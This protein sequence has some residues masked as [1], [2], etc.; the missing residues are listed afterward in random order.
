M[1][2]G[3]LESC[4]HYLNYTLVQ[5]K[6]DSFTCSV[7]ALT[8]WFHLNLIGIFKKFRLFPIKSY[9]CFYC[10]TY[11]KQMG[12]ITGRK[13]SHK[14]APPEKEIIY[15]LVFTLC[16]LVSFI[17]WNFIHLFIMGRTI[18]TK[19]WFCWKKSELFK[20]TNKI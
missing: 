16:I 19:I 4:C 7:L 3:N 15:L 6:C 11:N 20:Y 12:E 17:F 1:S 18:K 9:F 5:K 13:K 10:A 2:S 14:N 8:Y